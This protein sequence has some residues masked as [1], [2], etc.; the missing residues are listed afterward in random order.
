VGRNQ[1]G[2]VSIDATWARE[3]WRHGGRRGET[4]WPYEKEWV[5]VRVT[6][7]FHKVEGTATETRLELTK[8]GHRYGR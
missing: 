4:E 2:E 1:V 3:C 7:E 5:P 8:K 6:D